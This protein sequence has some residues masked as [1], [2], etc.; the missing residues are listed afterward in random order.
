[1]HG[2]V[3]EKHKAKS[4]QVCHFFL[5]LSLSFVVVLMLHYEL[6]FPFHCAILST[7]VQQLRNKNHHLEVRDCIWQGGT[8][9]GNQKL[10]GGTKFGS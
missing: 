5:P 7:K 2:R 4:N 3:K 1:M 8:N 10:S 9:F 6:N